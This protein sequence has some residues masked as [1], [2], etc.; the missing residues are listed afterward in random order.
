MRSSWNVYEEI[1]GD[2]WI[3]STLHLTETEEGIAHDC[4]GKIVYWGSILG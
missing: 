3:L 2:C 1:L 4:V